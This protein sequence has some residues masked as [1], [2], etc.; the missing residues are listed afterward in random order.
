MSDRD[1]GPVLHMIAGAVIGGLTRA[2]PYETLAVLAVFGYGR[3]VLQHKSFLL[4]GHQWIEAVCWP[5]G[6]WI[7]L[8]VV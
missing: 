1:F 5:I 8:F 2:T 7:A 4:S 3:E 6:G